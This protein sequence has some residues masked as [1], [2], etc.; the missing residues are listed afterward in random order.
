MPTAPLDEEPPEALVAWAEPGAPEERVITPDPACGRNSDQP[1]Q[2]MFV[3]NRHKPEIAGGFV[4]LLFVS[5][6]AS[7]NGLL[8]QVTTG[9]ILERWL[10]RKEHQGG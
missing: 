6:Y 5:M 1:S 7:D 8:R 9:S 4:L 3:V 2:R 10:M